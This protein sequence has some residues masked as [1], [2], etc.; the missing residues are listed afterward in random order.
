MANILLVASSTTAPAA[1]EQA[2][3]THLTAA[4]HVVTSVLASASDSASAAGKHLVILSD[5]ADITGLGTKYS[6]VGQGVIS[7]GSS[8]R[9]LWQNR[10]F[11]GATGTHSGVSTTTMA[12]LGTA[13]TAGLSGTQTVFNPAASLQYAESVAWGTGVVAHATQVAQPTRYALATYNAGATLADGTAA[14]GK[15]AALGWRSIAI[16]SLTTVAFTILDAVVEW[17]L[18]PFVPAVKAR[19]GG[20]WVEKPLTRSGS[21][22]WVDMRA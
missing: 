19:V 21:G 18:P 12:C 1:G 5:A 10:G 7:L 4:G 20:Q 11:I 6:G 14:S 13:L 2:L 9:T 17:A 8:G 15:R 16:P 3:I 22:L